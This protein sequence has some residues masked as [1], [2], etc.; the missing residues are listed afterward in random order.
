MT[1][2]S[3]VKIVASASA[4]V[5]A[6]T[7]A[8]VFGIAHVQHEQKLT[9]GAVTAATSAPQGAPVVRSDASAVANE[10]SPAHTAVQ[11]PP[12]V[13]SAD[14]ASIA[15]ELAGPPEAAGQRQSSPTFD[16]VRI[17]AGG[18]GVVAGRAAPGATVDLMR[19]DER[20]DRAVANASGEF[21]MVPPRLPAGSYELTL[22]AR[23]PDGTVTSSKHGAAVTVNDAGPGIRA[24]QSRAELV[25]EAASQPR[26]S[27]EPRL[28]P[29]KPQE[30]AGLEPAH[31]MHG[32]SASDDGASSPAA[33]HAM[34]N[35]VVSAG[36][37]LW[38]ISR[39]TYGDGSRYALV[40]RANRGRIRNP[41][42][43]YPGQTLV[44]PAKH[45]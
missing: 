5:V 6:G 9:V 39:I 20:L 42:L 30:S 16:I 10:A 45:N 31:A 23:S 44:L 22:S 14:P 12:A 2:V 8:L 33:A 17:E 19:G 26:P 35:K 36:D 37:S 3:I 4:F 41:N 21:V 29:G 34:P 13:A 25:P 40:Y 27:P 32:S 43:I 24:A 1:P 28:R 38:R 18:D 11:G 7:A 15:A